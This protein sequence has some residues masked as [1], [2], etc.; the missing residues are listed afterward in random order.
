MPLAYSQTYSNDNYYSFLDSMLSDEKP[1]DDSEETPEK[2]KGSKTGGDT[3]V[4]CA[5]PF[6][7]LPFC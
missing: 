3:R 4:F 5:L 2:A 6:L 7:A 1:M